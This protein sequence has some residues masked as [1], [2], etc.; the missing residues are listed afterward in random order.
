MRIRQDTED[1]S[2]ALVTLNGR[3]V[4]CLLEA[5][6]EEG[7]VTQILT[8]TY[9]EMYGIEKVGSPEL[10]RVPFKRYGKV[11]FVGYTDASNI[12]AVNCASAYADTLEIL[13][14]SIRSGR[15]LAT[16]ICYN[17]NVERWWANEKWTLF[18]INGLTMSITY[19]DP[20]H[21]SQVE[22]DRKKFLEENPDAELSNS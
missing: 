22:S 13:A 9:R 18:Q 15:T 11:E 5:D 14:A 21:A 6:T 16:S 17:R 8:N 4:G 2:C 1:Q 7:W 10:E 12:S 19:H 3:L 20:E